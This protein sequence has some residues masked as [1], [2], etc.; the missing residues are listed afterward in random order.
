M[1]P[2]QARAKEL[3][4]RTDLFSFG[5]V[6]YEMATGQLAF[7]GESTAT[8]LEAILNRAPVAPVRL[9]PNLP[10]KLEETITKA[11]E[12]D[13]NLRYQHA[14]D[15]RAELLRLKRDSSSSRLTVPAP[16]AKEQ[17]KTESQ[18]VASSGASV[19]KTRKAYL[20]GAA[21]LLLAAAAGAFLLFRLNRSAP[22]ASKDWQ[23]LTYFTDSVVYPAVSPDGRMLA[24]IRAED[25]FISSGQ[26]Y[27]KFLPDGQPVALTHD[28]TLKLS[29]EFSPDGSR[30]AYSTAV[31]WDV[32]EVTVLGGEPHQLFTN[33]SSLTWIDKGKR[34]LFSEIRNSTKMDVVTTDEGRGDVRV[35]YSPP[36]KGS[37]AHHSYLSP[38]GRW[39]LVVQMEESG[40]IGPCRMVSF[41]GGADAK[42]VGPPHSACYGGAWSIDGKWIY[43]SVA[44]DGESHIWRQRFPDGEPE[45]VTT[46]PT[47]QIGVAMSPDG[48]SLITS[49]GSEDSTVWL[50][51]T[52]GEHQI[53]SEGSGYGPAFSYD[54]SKLYYLISNAQTRGNELWVNDLSGGKPERFLPGYSMRGYS[55]SHDGKAIA[56][57]KADAG[58][59]SS[60][61][62]VPTNHHTSPERVSSKSSEDSVY[63]LPDGDM[64]F[65]AIEGGQNFLY[66][67]KADGSGRTKITPSRITDIFSVSADGRWV[68]A[69]GPGSDP[70]ATFGTFAFAVDGSKIVPLCR[71][72]CNVLWD[73]PGKFMFVY[74]SSLSPDPVWHTLPLQPDSG[75]PRLPP[76]GI[77][78][79][80]DFTAMSGIVAIRK[81]VAS[82]MSPSIY[83]YVRK[84]VHRNLY[85]IPLP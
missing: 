82:A 28:A 84:D 4:A 80:G 54:G 58:D 41:A 8:I 66:R 19:P 81:S 39:M 14:S 42:A 1:S 24:F 74:F 64:V 35:V 63:F 2:E 69:C 51:D 36:G 26:I 16:D 83:A 76:G 23:Q 38:D 12:K 57:V 7:Q 78:R 55:I 32:W 56:F 37:M 18:H 45:Q 52:G 31:P 34:L 75:L 65:R 67:M 5:A 71:G 50:H 79:N 49:V 40:E 62:L 59:R 27:V 44:K 68:A 17:P 29:P 47:F 15:L 43:L 85:R 13:R 25:P 22:P 61:W 77:S 6:L 73:K 53:S 70:D 30:I 21:L 11:L 60:I 3:D 10:S 33:A 72:Y 46:G 9:N 48:K 20:I